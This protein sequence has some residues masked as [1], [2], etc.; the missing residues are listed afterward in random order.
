MHSGVVDFPFFIASGDATELLEAIDKTLDQVAPTVDGKVKRAATT[1]VL[2]AWD[3]DP[4]AT[5]ATI[6]PNPA[7]AISFV[8]NNSPPGRGQVVRAAGVALKGLG[9]APVE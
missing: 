2:F 5:A 1:F 3:G 8:A 4:N 7:S 9:D 6:R